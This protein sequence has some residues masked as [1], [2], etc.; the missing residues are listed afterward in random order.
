M[1]P[2]LT[3]ILGAGSTQDLGIGPPNSV[4]GMPSTEDL[5]LRIANMRWPATVREGA[6]IL[7]GPEE[8][9]PSFGRAI[10]IL[11]LIYR[12]LKTSFEKHVDFELVLHALEELEPI[13]NLENF[14]N[15]H[16]QFRPV[17]SAFT[18][19]SQTLS[20]IN[21][22]DLLRTV[23]RAVIEQIYEAVIDRSQI[24]DL[25]VR[26]ALNLFIRIIECHFQIAVFNLNYDDVV[27]GAHLS[28]LDGFIYEKDVPPEERE[29]RPQT[30]ESRLF[31]QWQ[32]SS[33]PLL[34]HPHGSV[35]F[36]YS[37]GEFGLCKYR[38]AQ[39][40]LSSI[41][42]TTVSDKYS[43]GRILSPTPIISGLGKS[44]KLIENPRPFG[45]YYRALIDALL[46]CER[47]LVIGYGGRDDHINTWLKEYLER[48][49]AKRKI[50]W[51]CKLPGTSVG[52]PSREKDLIQ[53]LSGPGGF[54]EGRDFDN[55]Q[56]PQEF[57]LCKSLGLVPSGF[58]VSS[59][60]EA[61]IINFLAEKI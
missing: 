26:A 1:R 6:P 58:P 34:A 28:W 25:A 41:Q 19:I 35:R 11:P 44:A 7:L 60:T 8:R 57:R 10:P 32:T 3:I 55:P 47:L 21:D 52:K 23:R 56:D 38:N 14:G 2:R 43:G 20:F 27:D 12:T 4:L 33:E 22:G 46:G 54:Q 36:G 24:K 61:Q 51:I 13:G 59:E 17:L 18:E 39:V 53:I 5:T 42:E 40:A 48:H 15:V 9:L 29:Y 50:A 31:D 45:Y 30:F 16:P 49:G 37:S